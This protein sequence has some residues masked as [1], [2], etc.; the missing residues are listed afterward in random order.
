MWLRADSDIEAVMTLK[1]WD[2]GSD[3]HMTTL[4]PSGLPYKTRLYLH[5]KH[6]LY[7]QEY[8]ILG[9]HQCGGSMSHSSRESGVPRLV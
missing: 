4:T 3:P 6:Y 1:C 7:G 2:C 8:G 9:V 5:I